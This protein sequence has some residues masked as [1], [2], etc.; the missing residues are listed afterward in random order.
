MLTHTRY[1]SPNIIV[2][3]PQIFKIF[4]YSEDAQ[5]VDP[6]CQNY[7]GT[8]CGFLKTKEIY[9][10]SRLDQANAEFKILG[11]IL[12]FLYMA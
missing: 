2:Q 8:Y 10:T 6:F 12:Q 1:A 4:F 3:D 11:M 9:V 7:R 5:L